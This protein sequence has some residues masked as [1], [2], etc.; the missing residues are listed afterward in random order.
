MKDIDEK[1]QRIILFFIGE[2]AQDCVKTK[3]FLN[4]TKESLIKLIS[5]DYVGNIKF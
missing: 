3:S 5:S 1:L 2:N 4:L